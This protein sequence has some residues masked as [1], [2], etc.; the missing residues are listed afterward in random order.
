MRFLQPKTWIVGSF[1]LFVASGSVH[2]LEMADL[3][4]RIKVTPP[5]RVAFSETRHNALLK[6]PLLLTGYLEYPKP[7]QLRKV[8][9]TPFEESMLVDGD[10][11]EI[12][13]D[14]KSKRLSLKNRKPIQLILQS[15]ESLLAGNS[16]ALES[17]FAA[18]LSGTEDDW[19]LELTPRSKSLAMHLRLLT[20]TGDQASLTDIRFDLENGEWQHLEVNRLDVDP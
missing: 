12:T 17:I 16:E 1:L 10:Q 4:A 7:G 15:I 2:A 13:R 3:L 5:D 18:K 9:K 6:E 20:V 8:V 11:V 19:C 14:G